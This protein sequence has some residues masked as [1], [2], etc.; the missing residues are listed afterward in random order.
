MSEFRRWRRKPVDLDAELRASRPTPSDEFV[1]GLTRD[2]RATDIR[3]TGES[4]RMRV[5]FAAAFT[6]AILGAL[7]AVGGLGYAASAASDAAHAVKSVVVKSNTPTNHVS[8]VQNT[9]AQSQYRPGCGLGDENHIHTGPPGQGG[10]CP[11]QGNP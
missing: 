3:A 6:V 2:L 10:V 5:G 7:S 9:P 8:T 4:R 1:R 11:A